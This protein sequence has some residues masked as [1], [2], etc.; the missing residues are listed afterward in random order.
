MVS[1]QGGVSNYNLQ[2]YIQMLQANG[3][4]SALYLHTYFIFKEVI[5]KKKLFLWKFWY[6]LLC[7]SQFHQVYNWRICVVL[8]KIILKFS[9]LN[10]L[11][12]FNLQLLLFLF[13]SLK[14]LTAIWVRKD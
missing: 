9:N 1:D 10:K 13:K 5:R 12:K 4:D 6:V 3:L 7:L 8:I 2:K 14:L 11:F